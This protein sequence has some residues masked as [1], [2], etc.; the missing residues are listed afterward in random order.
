M[1]VMVMMTVMM[2][3]MVVV[4]DDDDD[5]YD[6]YGVPEYSDGFHIAPKASHGDCNSYLASR[7][8]RLLPQDRGLELCMA[9]WLL[10]CC[11]GL[12]PWPPDYCY[13]FQ[14]MRMCMRK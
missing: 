4:P 6:D 5:S 14:S 3:G 11:L 1:I 2:I 12:V 10:L 13:G 8:F 9:S 7:L